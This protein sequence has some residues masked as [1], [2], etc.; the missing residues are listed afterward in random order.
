MT[1]SI[2]VAAAGLALL[3]LPAVAEPAASPLIVSVYTKYDTKNCPHQRGK[4]VEDYGSWRCGGYAGIPVLVS[5][6]DQRML[7]SF[8]R[9]AARE[10]AASQTLPSFNNAY[11]GTI[12]W[13]L[14]TLPNGK[15]R[16]FATILRWNVRQESDERTSTGRT[17]VVTRLG[18]NGVCHVGYVDGRD[19]KGNELARQ[20]ADRHARKFRC[21]TDDARQTEPDKD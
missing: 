13:R 4:D 11:E 2:V 12:E 18:P 6:G 15:T 14:E 8:G 5:A 1:K 7:I 21:G 10:P 19:P 16:P 20:L 9:N 17:L 3:G